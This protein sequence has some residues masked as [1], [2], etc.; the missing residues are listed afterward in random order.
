MTIAKNTNKATRIIRNAKDVRCYSLSN[1]FTG[2]PLAER[3]V[4]WAGEIVEGHYVR[5]VE[6]SQAQFLMRELR[7]NTHA[8]LVTNGDAFLLSVHSNLWYEFLST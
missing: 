4:M 3:P 2:D 5:I 8:K 6:V 1:N 7:E